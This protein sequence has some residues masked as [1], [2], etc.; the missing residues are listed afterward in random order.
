VTADR[1]RR[2]I[3]LGFA[4]VVGV[5]TAVLGAF[6]HQMVVVLGIVWP[7]GLVLAPALQIGGLR[8]A[9]DLD[10]RSGPWWCSAG[11]VIAVLALSLPRASGDIVVP[12]TA[13]G[14][15]FLAVG[16]AVAVAGPVL[17]AL[18][19]V[20]AQADGRERDLSSGPGAVR[21]VG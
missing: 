15:T 3:A 4:L 7:V 12:A 11:W 5:T 14:Y 20:R 8:W 9:R 10:P 18:Q 19:Q 13:T 6:V 21:R 2:G 16:L 17:L 1:R